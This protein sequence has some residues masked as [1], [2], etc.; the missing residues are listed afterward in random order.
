MIGARAIAGLACAALLVGACGD[1]AARANAARGT[2]CLDLDLRAGDLRRR[3]PPTAADRQQRPA[4]GSDERPWRSER[5]GGQDGPRPAWLARRQVHGRRAGV[6][7]GERRLAAAQPGQVRPERQGLRGRPG[8]G[9]RRS[10]PVTSTCTAAT[11]PIVNSVPGGPLPVIS[12]SNTYLGLT[13]AGPGVVKGHPAALYPTGEHSFVRMAP[14]DD[15]QGAAGALYGAATRRSATLRPASRRG[16][17]CRRGNGLRHGGDAPGHERHRHG[18]VGPA[19][20][21]ATHVSRSALAAPARTASTSRAMRSPTTARG[22]SRISVGSSGLT[23]RSSRPTASTSPPRSWRAR[24]RGPRA[25]SSPWP[26]SRRRSSRPRARASLGSSSSASAL[27]RAATRCTPPRRRTLSWTRSRLGRHARRGAAQSVSHARARRAARRLRDR[28]LWRHDADGDRRVPGA[29]GTHP[30]GHDDH[31]VGRPAGPQVAA[32]LPA[33]TA[34]HTAPLPPRRSL[35]HAIVTATGGHRTGGSRRFV[36]TASP[37]PPSRSRC[38]RARWRWPRRRTCARATRSPRASRTRRRPRT[39]GR[40]T[41]STPSSRRPTCARPT[42]ASA[43]RPAA[44]RPRAC[45]SSRSR[46]VALAGATPGSAQRGCS[47][48]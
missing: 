2:A 38:A 24:A 5:S 32:P 10:G 18:G 36:S 7:R 34:L 29:R 31:A 43:S 25:S 42:T 3:R 13:R 14:A 30:L 23:S 39:T 44:R 27:C 33:F 21:R 9:R 45:G 12:M 16:V 8:R 35:R 4:A 40:P 1:T 48:S 6:R 37:S 11:L 19:R 46:R 22:S 26:R 17:G 15:L 47:A 41:R 28:P 20:A